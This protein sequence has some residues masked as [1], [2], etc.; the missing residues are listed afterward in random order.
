MPGSPSRREDGVLSPE[1]SRPR[2]LVWGG[3]AYEDVWFPPQPASPPS[4]SRHGTEGESRRR[5]RRRHGPEPPTPPSSPPDAAEKAPLPRGFSSYLLPLPLNPGDPLF[6]GPP[7]NDNFTASAP[8][9]VRPP[10]RAPM[11]PRLRTPDDLD[12]DDEDD[13]VAS[14]CAGFCSCCG[15]TDRSWRFSGRDRGEKMAV[16]CKLWSKS[17]P[18][19]DRSTHIKTPKVD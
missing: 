19:G 15:P 16:Q 2:R 3:E 14:G 17:L 9:A 18:P 10:P 6:P 4:C 11:I 5:R 1:S 12:D 7:Q 8:V 13:D